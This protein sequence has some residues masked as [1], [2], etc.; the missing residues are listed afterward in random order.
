MDL[1][2]QEATA[3]TAPSVVTAVTTLHLTASVMNT[4]SVASATSMVPGQ[5]TDTTDMVLVLIMATPVMATAGVLA[6]VPARVSVS[7]NKSVV[8]GLV[9]RVP[10]GVLLPHLPVPAASNQGSISQLGTSHQS[11]CADCTSFLENV[12]RL[13]NAVKRIL[14]S[15]RQDLNQNK[16]NFRAEPKLWLSP[17]LFF[18]QK[19]YR[20]RR[21]SP[22]GMILLR[23]CA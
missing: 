10:P 8:P 22:N 6:P 11:S 9:A 2:S 23:R 16:T 15:Y 14:A 4:D 13:S 7:S 12:K 20:G 17:I 3:C 1:A 21:P 19:W 5:A 18:I